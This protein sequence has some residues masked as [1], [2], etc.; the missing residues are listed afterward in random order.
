MPSIDLNNL[1]LLY[2]SLY[3]INNEPEIEINW[4]RGEIETN[5]Q[6]Q[7]QAFDFMCLYIDVH[8]N[9]PCIHYTLSS[10]AAIANHAM[11]HQVTI[12]TIPHLTK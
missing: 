2:L 7:S 9:T 8:E 1:K 10:Y 5:L 4:N 12:T 3:V 6:S 11:S